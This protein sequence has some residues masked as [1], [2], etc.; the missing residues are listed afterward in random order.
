[1]V[2]LKG[3]NRWVALLSLL[4]VFSIVFTPFS[5][6]TTVA[7][8]NDNLSDDPRFSAPLIIDSAAKYDNESSSGNGTSGNPYIIQNKAYNAESGIYAL[9][10][11]N[12]NSYATFR[13]VVFYGTTLDNLVDPQWDIYRYDIAAVQIIN[14]GNI[15]FE[16]CTFRNSFSGIVINGSS[17]LIKIYNNTFRDLSYAGIYGVG[18]LAQVD[19]EY[20]RMY[21]IGSYGVNL[22]A[23]PS[24]SLMQYNTMYD[25]NG[26]AIKLKDS[27]GTNVENNTLYR[28]NYAA[29]HVYGVNSTNIQLNYINQA[30]KGIYAQ[31]IMDTDIYNNN[32]INCSG[33]GIMADF[34]GISQIHFNT[35]TG[36]YT[37]ILVRNDNIGG[38][39]T[40]KENTVNYNSYGI[41]LSTGISSTV[42]LNTVRFNLLYGIR[43]AY[44]TTAT[45]NNN[46][47]EDNYGVGIEDH[48]NNWIS[49]HSNN[50]FR[51]KG[52]GLQIYESLHS[53]IG[54]TYQNLI[55]NTSQ[56]AVVMAGRYCRLQN[57]II[58][59]SEKNGVW[60][61]DDHNIISG[62]SISGSAQNGIYSEA[63]NTTITGANQITNTGKTGIVLL[64]ANSTIQTA[65]ISQTGEHGMWI[66][67]ISSTINN[68]NIYVANLSGIAVGGYANSF[69]TN[70]MYNSGMTLIE[71]EDATNMTTHTI[72]TTNQINDGINSVP[73]YY[74]KNMNGGTISGSYRS[75]IMVN[76]IGVTI[77]WLTVS[78]GSIG[79]QIYNS[80]NILVSGIT[81]NN[82]KINGIRASKTNGLTITGSTIRTSNPENIYAEGNNLLIQTNTQ[83]QLSGWDGIYVKGDNFIIK[84]S[85]VNGSGINGIVINGNIATINNT[86]I[87]TTGQIGIVLRGSFH[88]LN[89][90]RVNTTGSSA[91]LVEDSKDNEIKS[92]IIQTTSNTAIVYNRVNSTLFKSNQI[93]TNV[94]NIFVNHSNSNTFESNTL[95]GL[96]FDF[97]GNDVSHFASHT[98]NF[99]QLNGKSVQYIKNRKSFSLATAPYA[100]IIVADS[101]VVSI[102]SIT[103]LSNTYSGIAVYYSEYVTIDSCPIS[104]TSYAGIIIRNSQNI[105]VKATSLAHNRGTIGGIYIRDSSNSE[106]VENSIFNNTNGIY[107]ENIEAIL[108]WKSDFSTNVGTAIQIR[109]SSGSSITNNTFKNN[110]IKTIVSIDCRNDYYTKN[111]FENFYQA[112][113]EFQSGYGCLVQYN[114]FKLGYYTSAV[115]MSST[116]YCQITDNQIESFTAGTGI[117]ADE[118]SNLNY[119]RWNTI[120]SSSS[121]PMAYGILALGANNYIMENIIQQASSGIFIRGQGNYIYK[122]QIYSCPTGITLDAAPYAI[123]EQNQIVG[124]VQ[125]AIQFQNSSDYGLATKNAIS[126]SFRTFIVNYSIY[127]NV[128]FNRYC[129]NI[130]SATLRIGVSSSQLY[131]EWNSFCLEKEEGTSA[132]DILD[133]NDPENKEYKRT[134][135]LQWLDD[136]QA[137]IYKF[138]YNYGILI[139]LVVSLGILLATPQGRRA[140]GQ[141]TKRRIVGF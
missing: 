20:N 23:R 81:A 2:R 123:L 21:N 92:C 64:G 27:T 38:A 108:C 51:N 110:Q 31:N 116:D 6:E 26:T 69:A 78:Y 36:S 91:L 44:T 129:N 14:S 133:L 126:L 125:F 115:R 61:L 29:I 120:L 28:I 90:D 117:E 18:S 130:N 17:A 95:T 139:I 60:V 19:V 93:S 118:A 52:N 67:S 62:N 107:M 63:F 3:I 12:V 141:L 66:E 102:K 99:N 101:S 34:I 4:V 113:I 97:D 111:I 103:S 32:I 75:V 140:L 109:N 94:L 40:I 49:I 68:N 104:Y 53:E 45:V 50:I 8:Q 77:S 16:N 105:K 46:S 86:N 39:T 135:E 59:N 131:E 87:T 121:T 70:T 11:Q 82:N 35:I 43:V 24:G 114:E 15:R 106:F 80:T 41:W 5:G 136:L 58:Q 128:S 132:G 7:T 74:A 76:C 96:G 22:A 127:V 10:I 134:S 56:N 13:N 100:Q 73:I 138:L 25:I 1:M 57:N 83:I 48:S 98:I 88:K 30:S 65:T 122:N 112:A 79:V 72:P 71:Y 9:S 89:N 55:V 42:E 47:V 119:I 124:S 37:G 54:T 33:E 137:S 84:D 85:V